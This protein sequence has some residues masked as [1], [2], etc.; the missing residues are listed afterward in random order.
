MIIKR[1]T[2]Y[3]DDKEGGGGVDPNGH[4][5]STIVK[6]SFGRLPWPNLIPPFSD[7]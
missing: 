3:I 4:V 6:I 5:N 2:K 1:E 7:A